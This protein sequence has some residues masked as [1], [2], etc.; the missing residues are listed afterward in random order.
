[1]TFRLSDIDY[2]ALAEQAALLGRFI[3]SPENVTEKTI[4]DHKQTLEGLWNFC[5]AVLDAISCLGENKP[6]ALLLNQS[7][8]INEAG[9]YYRDGSYGEYAHYG[10]RPA[11]DGTQGVN[12]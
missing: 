6:V 3:D 1:M 10:D 9:Y 8:S 4:T 2:D 7:E 5:H 12:R 11:A